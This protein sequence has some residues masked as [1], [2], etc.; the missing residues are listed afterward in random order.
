MITENGSIK[1]KQK[2]QHELDKETGH[3]VKCACAEWGKAIPC[4]YEAT[5]YNNLAK[6][7]TSPYTDKHYNI[8]VEL[9]Y[10][11]GEQ[12]A[13]FDANKNLIGEFSI[14]Q[15]KE[16]CAVNEIQITV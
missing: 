8:L 7:E 16:L 13:L 11:K 4:Q 5:S 1:F 14:I 3:F 10:L 15:I 2:G 12:I 6:S 9:Q